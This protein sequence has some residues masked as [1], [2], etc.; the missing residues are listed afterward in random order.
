MSHKD[1]FAQSLVEAITSYGIGKVIEFSDGGGLDE[2]TTLLVRD[3]YRIKSLVHNLVQSKLFQ[4][5]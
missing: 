1:G 5:K 4:T 2:M 3:G